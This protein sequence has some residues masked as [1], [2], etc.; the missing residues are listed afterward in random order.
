MTN[1]KTAIAATA[2][3][4]AAAGALALGTGTAA[5]APSAPVVDNCYSVV[6]SVGVP[7]PTVIGFGYVPLG[8]AVVRDGTLTA[9][10][11]TAPIGADGAVTIRGQRA[12]LTVDP[13][14]ELS[15]EPSYIVRGVPGVKALYPM[16]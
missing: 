7:L 15:P 13:G 11:E 1:I 2:L 3:A 12:T 6:S 16:C 10:G 5:A 4:G 9:F 14:E 8:R